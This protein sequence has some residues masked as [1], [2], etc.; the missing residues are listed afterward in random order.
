MGNRSVRR[1]PRRPLCGTGA[2][3]R[4]R[5]RVARGARVGG[6]GSGVRLPGPARLRGSAGHGRDRCN[7][8]RRNSAAHRVG[9]ARGI[10]V[11]RQRSLVSGQCG[12]SSRPA[13]RAADPV[14][15]GR[16]GPGRAHGHGGTRAAHCT[17]RAARHAAAAGADHRAVGAG[18]GAE[19]ASRSAHRRARAD[20]RQRRRQPGPSAAAAERERV[21]LDLG[22]AL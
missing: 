13:C 14:R 3:R 20:S 15:V 7:V 2:A 16:E 9:G 4:R 6:C 19:P 10:P 12:A 1:S 8:A 21:G 11:S 17:C 5:G 22:R 18:R